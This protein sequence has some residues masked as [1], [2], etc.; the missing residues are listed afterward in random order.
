[1]AGPFSYCCAMSPGSLPEPVQSCRK[2]RRQQVQWMGVGCL[3]QVRGPRCQRLIPLRLQTRYRQLAGCHRDSAHPPPVPDSTAFPPNPS[4]DN[5]GLERAI[6]RINTGFNIGARHRLGHR[7]W[8]SRLQRAEGR[9]RR[10]GA[11]RAGRRAGRLRRL[12]HRRRAA[13]QPPHRTALARPRTRLSA[14]RQD[15]QP[16]VLEQV[17]KSFHWDCLRP[18]A[19]VACDHRRIETRS[20]RSPTNSPRTRPA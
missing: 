14:H 9:G 17:C 12:R 6:P 2:P 1:M 4:R 19:T 7:D 8:P 15:N 18:Y 3:N 16:T 5:P 10:G 11:A 20:I 13:H